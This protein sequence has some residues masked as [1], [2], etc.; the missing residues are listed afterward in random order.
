MVFIMI[1]T[2]ND[3]HLSSQT[4]HRHE[5]VPVAT[6]IRFNQHTGQRYSPARKVAETT[7]VGDLELTSED[8]FLYLE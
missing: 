5:A 1:E 3:P 8:L 6:P 2:W 7:S 4:C